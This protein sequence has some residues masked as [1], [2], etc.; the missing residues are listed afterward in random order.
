MGD[1]CYMKR[2][3]IESKRII[4]RKGIKKKIKK[5]NEKRI[6]KKPEKI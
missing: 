2:G 4:I 1:M 6:N 5:S 3:E